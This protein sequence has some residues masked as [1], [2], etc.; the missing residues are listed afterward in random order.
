MSLVPLQGSHYNARGKRRTA[1]TQAHIANMY[2]APVKGL[3]FTQTLV[4]ADPESAITLENLIPR[5]YGI[6]LRK[7][8]SQWVTGLDGEVRSLMSYVS[9]D[10]TDRLLAGTSGGKVYDVSDLATPV[11]LL[12]HLPGDFPGEWSWIN[13]TTVDTSYL[14]AV[15]SGVGYYIYDGLTFTAVAQGTAPGEISGP[16][17]PWVPTPINPADFAYIFEWKGRVWF[18]ARN[19]SVAYYL[20]PDQITGEVKAFDFGPFMQHGGPLWIGYN[21]T[22]DAGDGIDDKLVLFGLEG[23]VLVY[24][25]TDP[26]EASKFAKEGSYFIGHLPIGRRC[27]SRFASDI[28]ILSERGLCFLSEL[29]RGHGFFMNA[30]VAQRVNDE[31]A[32][33]VASKMNSRYWEVRFLPHE[34]MIL[35]NT[36][37]LS[38][39]DVQWA[40][41]VNSKAFC[42]LT[43]MPMLTVQAHDRQTY[44]GDSDGNVWL[45]FNGSSDGATATERG[46]DLEGTVM[47]AFLPHGEPIRLKRFL[48]VRPAF[49]APIAPSIKVVM[50]NDWQFVSPKGS[51]QFAPAPGSS[52]WDTA[53]WN[54]SVW[55]GADRSYGAWIGVE[56]MGY[57]GALAMKVR[58]APG[59]TFVSWQSLTTAG[60][61][62]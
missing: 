46:A 43:K 42:K 28:A 31:L 40:F 3:D 38:A 41:D 49:I 19:S 22:V 50:N 17:A 59:T 15:S 37:T 26:N 25:G 45:G 27:V 44:F 20:P 4:A 56:G 29:L 57:Y 8:Y 62:L 52:L 24:A 53:V 48:M 51:P 7:G 18:L 58:G 33:D 9:A 30:E 55:N 60:G 35:I 16:P 21:W 2:A 11:E 47:T 12:S 36:P 61:I 10:G 6:E 34:Q 1:V 13:Y 5:K 23:D 14:L 32:H 39:V 54:T